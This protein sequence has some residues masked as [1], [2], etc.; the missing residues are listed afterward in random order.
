MLNGIIKI[1]AKQ[2]LQSDDCTVKDLVK[3]I[4]KKGELRD[5]QIQAI[6]TEGLIKTRSVDVSTTF[7]T[8]DY[9]PIVS[10]PN[11]PLGL[12]TKIMSMT[13]TPMRVVSLGLSRVATT[14]SK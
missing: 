13:I 6:E 11:I 10:R 8:S 7:D 9:P 14:V 12:N 1:K 3:Y 5:T 4:R 2:W